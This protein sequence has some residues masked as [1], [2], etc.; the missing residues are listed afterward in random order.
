MLGLAQGRSAVIAERSRDLRYGNKPETS[1]CSYAAGDRATGLH[2]PHFHCHHQQNSSGSCLFQGFSVFASG[3]YI[4]REARKAARSA[5]YSANRVIYYLGQSISPKWNGRSCLLSL[6]PQKGNAAAT[7]LGAGGTPWELSRHSLCGRQ[8]TG[9]APSLRSP[10]LTQKAS[11]THRFV[12]LSK[13]SEGSQGRLCSPRCSAREL[14]GSS[15]RPANRPRRKLLFTYPLINILFFFHIQHISKPPI[16]FPS[17]SPAPISIY[18]LSIIS[19]SAL[20]PDSHFSAT[21]SITSQPSRCNSLTSLPGFLQALQIRPVQLPEAG[22][23][24]ILP[25]FLPKGCHVPEALGQCPQER[26]WAFG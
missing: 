4:S 5:F 2:P 18:N 17:Q 12:L 26:A 13:F 21:I 8:D 9:P 22:F 23:H 25:L 14:Q 15:Q 11:G 7:L 24:P 20:A 16:A 1:L 19:P 6:R 10:V 3:N